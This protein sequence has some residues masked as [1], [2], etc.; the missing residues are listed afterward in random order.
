M[1]RNLTLAQIAELNRLRSA[2]IAILDFVVAR[3]NLT[4]IAS[5][6]RDV[7]EEAY[8]KRNLGGLR[9]IRR[10]F[11]EWVGDLPPSARDELERGLSSIEDQA[12]VDQ[13]SSALGRGRILTEEEYRAVLAK[14][15]E[16]Y[17]DPAALNELEL[18][19]RLLADFD[20]RVRIRD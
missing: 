17:A 3:G 5:E 13:L 14:I 18:L 20:R 4:E 11:Q 2:C 16:I 15:E 7:V 12:P 8:N 19:N 9:T 10:D 1:A 6:F